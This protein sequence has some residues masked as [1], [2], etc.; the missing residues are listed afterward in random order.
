M[1]PKQKT[2]TATASSAES[3]PQTSD[4]HQP[5]KYFMI[6]DGHSLIYRAYHAFPELS[7]A[8]GV[9]V[10]AVYG[11]ARILLV[12]IRDFRPAYTAVTFDHPTP[13]F[14]HTQF[15]AYKANRPEMPDDLKP[16]I[17]LVKDFVN[18]LNIPLFELP[19]FEADDVIG[20]LANQAC[21]LRAKAEVGSGYE[22][23]I[24]LI[25][26][27]DR[28]AL[29]LVNE[30]VHVWMP[31]RGKNHPEKEYDAETMQEVWGIKP[32]QVIE[33]KAL[34]GDGSDNIPGVAGVG[35]KTAQKLIAAY[36][37]L[38]H[39]YAGVEAVTADPT[40]VAQHP[41]LK[42]ALLTKLQ[43]GKEVAALSRQLATIDT[44]VPIQLDIE[45]CKVSSYEKETV[46]ALLQTWDFNSL[47]S[48]LPA[49]EF[50][51]TVQEALF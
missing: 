24:T 51:L 31:A 3:S 10:N 18:A 44:N 15:E 38:E 30:C 36:D 26:T 40:Q 14:R 32:Y 16:Q 39:V 46:L 9:L 19:G 29:Q 13:T 25:V 33:L 49:D 7:T 45:A 27:G 41:L 28:D 5:S 43:A 17:Q 47:V 34:M 20:T 1:M 42:G 11:F 23:L 6:V 50:E 21:Q 4:I 35:E 48:L 12:A 2:S 22:D 37:D 8:E